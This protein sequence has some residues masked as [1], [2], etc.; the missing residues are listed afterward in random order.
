MCNLNY[1]LICLRPLKIRKATFSP[2]DLPF[3]RVLISAMQTKVKAELHEA[4]FLA[5]CKATNVALQVAGKN[6]RNTPFGNCNC[7][8][9]SR[10]KIRTTL[11]FSQHYETSCLR[12]TS[13]QHFATQFCQNGPIRDHLLFARDFH[14][15]VCYCA[16]CKLRRKLQTCDTPSAT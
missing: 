12:V 4:I 14:Y 15:L 7:C 11:Y 1:S 2:S 10:K 13:P 16:C 3:F 5:A 9:A 6:S 8:C